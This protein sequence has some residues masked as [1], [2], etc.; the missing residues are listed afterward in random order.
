VEYGRLEVSVSVIAPRRSARSEDDRALARRAGRGDQ[1]AYAELYE[2]HAPG[3]LSFVQQ[4]VGDRAAAED[5]VQQ[6]FLAAFRTLSGGTAI[7]HPRAWL[8]HVARNNALTVVRDRRPAALERALEEDLLDRAA[9]VPAQIEQREA[10]QEV[11]RDIVALPAQQR[12]ALALFEIADLS[13][14]EIAEALDCT[15]AQVK[16][17]VFQAR[18]SLVGRRDARSASCASVREKLV[19]ARGGAFN[20]RV[21]RHH[22]R[23]CEPCTVFRNELRDR[24]RRVALLLPILPAP[25]LREAVLGATGTTGHTAAGAATVARPGHARRLAGGATAT[26]AAVGL[27]WLAWPGAPDPNVQTRARAAPTAPATQA[28]MPAATASPSPARASSSS[29]RASRRPRTVMAAA[30]PKAGVRKAGAPAAT[31]LVA[32]PA[33]AARPPARAPGPTSPAPQGPRA[34]PPPRPATPP[35]SA[36]PES[37][38]SPPAATTPT[39]ATPA[40]AAPAPAAPAPAEP[41]PAPAPPESAKPCTDHSHASPQGLLH[42]KG[43]HKC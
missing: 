35:P 1:A 19:A 17:L 24:R 41:A 40:P 27:A 13:Q 7:E 9:A 33:P 23:H 15:P 11:V 5:V 42:G 31:R 18:T 30:A 6:T 37:S 10:L 28:T 4:Y 8:Y 29:R 22:L 38:P 2:R 16:A 39:V 21:L 12:A 25:G 32:G 26:A 20:Q 3:L 34:D 43:H 36:P 14:A